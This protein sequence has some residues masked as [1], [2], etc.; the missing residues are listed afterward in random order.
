MPIASARPARFTAALFVLLASTACGRAPQAGESL[1]TLESPIATL[2]PV[3]AP[4]VT[5]DSTRVALPAV[6]TGCVAGRPRIS[7]AE[8]RWTTVP[9]A[10][11]D[12]VSVD[13]TVFKDGFQAERYASLEGPS[14]EPK[15][16]LF[17]RPEAALTAM[18]VRNISRVRRGDTTIVRVEQLDAGV[19]Y[20]WRLRTN[21]N[22]QLV[23]GAPIRVEAPTCIS[24]TP[25][26]V[27]Q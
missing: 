11:P 6:L 7:F 1:R 25:E 9:G 27:R 5:T 24:D 2:T 3:Q 18:S 8:I 22:G 14:N 19:N 20:L 13:F 15:V 21:L 4:R 23:A 26:G 16:Q 10:V 12:S 17:F